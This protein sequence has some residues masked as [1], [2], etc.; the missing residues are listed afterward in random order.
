MAPSCRDT[1]TTYLNQPRVQYAGGAAGLTQIA[2]Q[3]WIALY[4]N[5]MEAWTQ[6]RR[7]QVPSLMP[8]PNAVRNA[9]VLNGIPERMPY[10]DQEN[11]LNKANVDAAVAAQGFTASNDLWK[12][13][14]FTGRQ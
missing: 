14:W 4:M 3:L 11:V 1:I 5:G 12:P 9:G 10:D 7:T 8:G 13:L 2:Y 6:W